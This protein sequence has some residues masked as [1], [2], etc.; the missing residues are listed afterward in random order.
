MKPRFALVALTVAAAG[1]GCG[2]SSSTAPTPKTPDLALAAVVSLATPNGDDGAV[3]VTLKGPDL[4]SI[5]APSSAYVVYSRLSTSQE[6]RVF[7]I[8]NVA[9]GPLLTVKF[10]AGQQLAAYSATVEQVATRADALRGS[11]TGYQLTVSAAP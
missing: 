3:V 6:A 1:I 4:S 11:T 9:A 7:V 5:Q 2:D 10:A 8:G